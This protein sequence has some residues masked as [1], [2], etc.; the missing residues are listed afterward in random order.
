MSVDG[1]AVIGTTLIAAFLGFL[2]VLLQVRSGSRQLH[3]QLA[4]QQDASV[5]ESERRRKA[6]AT[7]LMLEVDDFCMHFARLYNVLLDPGSPPIL[8]QEAFLQFVSVAFTVY[9]NVA[10]KLGDLGTEAT[11]AVVKFYNKANAFNHYFQLGRSSVGG[12]LPVPLTNLQGEHGN[13]QIR[14]YLMA[15]ENP[16]SDLSIAVSEIQQLIRDLAETSGQ[17]RDALRGVAPSSLPGVDRL[18]EVVV[19]YAQKN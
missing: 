2:A 7:A 15:H 10:D 8:R 6:V 12:L 1:L 4:F 14:D 13:Q 19:Q 3:E 11:S 18:H 5:E 9:S 16:L 17:A